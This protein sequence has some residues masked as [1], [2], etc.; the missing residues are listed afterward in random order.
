MKVFLSI[1]NIGLA[2]KPQENQIVKAKKRA[3]GG[4]QE[5]EIK[6]AA[7]LIGNKGHAAVPG[8]MAGGLKAENCRAMQVFMLDFDDGI[9]FMDIRSRC[10]ETG[11]PI[12]F[13]YHTYSSDENRERFRVVFVHEFLIEHMM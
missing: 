1:D 2:E 12:S 3:V 10:E 4:W 8:H 9:S 11:I 5:I 7:D 6:E 13:A